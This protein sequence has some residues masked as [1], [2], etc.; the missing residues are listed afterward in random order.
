MALP[1]HFLRKFAKRF[2]KNIRSISSAA[3]GQMQA[4]DWPG[5]VRELEHLLEQS[6]ILC[7]S[8]QLELSKSLYQLK[9]EAPVA[10]TP[11]IKT[12]QEAERDN[13]LAALKATKGRIRGKTGAAVLLDIN[14]NTLDARMRKPGVRAKDWTSQSY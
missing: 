7:Q 5:N 10:T 2:G 11:R 9:A 4:Y 8:A 13:I 14:P 3:L 1:H 12:C 6:I